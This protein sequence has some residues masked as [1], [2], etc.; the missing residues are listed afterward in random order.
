MENQE[1][2]FKARQ[3]CSRKLNVTSISVEFS[4]DFRKNAKRVALIVYYM[5]EGKEKCFTALVAT[6]LNNYT[7]DNLFLELEKELLLLK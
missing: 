7:L 3:I 6:Y 2:A 5:A 4:F 1:I